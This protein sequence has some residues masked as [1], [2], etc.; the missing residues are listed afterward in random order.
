M[1]NVSEICVFTEKSSVENLNKMQEIIQHVQCC[2]STNVLFYHYAFRLKHLAHWS[3]PPERAPLWFH[4]EST[5]FAPLT[6]MNCI[7]TSLASQKQLHSI[8]SHIQ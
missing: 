6:P 1:K 8:I 4:I 5:Y 7:T 3:L 2:Y